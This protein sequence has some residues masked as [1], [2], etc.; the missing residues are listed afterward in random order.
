MRL[1]EIFVQQHS[2]IDSPQNI[3]LQIPAQ[4][5]V[6]TAQVAHHS[7]SKPQSYQMFIVA[8]EYEDHV[9]TTNDRLSYEDW[10]FRSQIGCRRIFF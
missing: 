8:E 3:S 1:A 5:V 9:K 6:D 4:L 2:N 7:D 10:S